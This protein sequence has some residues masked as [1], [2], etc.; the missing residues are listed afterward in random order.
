MMPDQERSGVALG[1]A[2]I[3]DFYHDELLIPAIKIQD[4]H[5]RLAAT[6]TPYGVTTNGV[7]RFV[8]RP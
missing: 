4:A 3:P 2:R 7:N 8:V 6:T 5:L 1:S